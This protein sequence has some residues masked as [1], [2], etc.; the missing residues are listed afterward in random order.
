MKPSCKSFNP[1]FLA[2]LLW[3]V[4]S[5]GQDAP[6]DIYSTGLYISE[7][8]GVGLF[9]GNGGD[10]GIA[11][12]VE[13]ALINFGGQIHQENNAAIYLKQGVDSFRGSFQNLTDSAFAS[14]AGTIVLEGDLNNEGSFSHSGQVILQGD[15]EVFFYGNLTDTN[16][17]YSVVANKDSGAELIHVTTDLDVSNLIDYQGAGCF[18]TNNSTLYLRNADTSSLRGFLNPGTYSTISRTVVTMGNE[19]GFK[20]E[21]ELGYNYDFPVANPATY[22]PIRIRPVSGPLY[23]DVIIRLE[24]YAGATINFN[25]TYSSLPCSP[26]PI[27]FQYDCLLQ[28]GVWRIDGR[29]DGSLIYQTYSFPHSSYF[30]DCAPSGPFNFRT[31]RSPNPGGD[32]SPYVDSVMSQQDLCMFVTVNNLQDLDGQAIPGG[33]YSS[34]SSIGVGAGPAGGGTLPVEWLYFDVTGMGLSAQLNWGTGVEVN[35]RG[36]GIYRSETLE[37]FE[38]IG[39]VDATDDPLNFSE[40]QFLDANLEMGKTYYYRIKQEDLDGESFWSEIRSYTA[41]G[42]FSEVKAFPNPTDGLLVLEKSMEWSDEIEIICYDMFGLMKQVESI[43]KPKQLQV[44]LGF[45]PPGSYMIKATDKVTG[46]IFTKKVMK[47]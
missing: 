41:T 43:H 25:N 34:F 3:S 20:R 36:F 27:D 10:S 26:G 16:A 22:N 6:Q 19:G 32:W 29:D 1:T 33:I 18:I 28:N 37:E 46:E 11:L 17:L 5:Y 38:P 23:S 47:H 44:D 8:R 13:G 21:V 24:P 9:V 39:F 42:P 45:L 4:F 7:G 35:N 31:M 15:D 14:L 40:Y 30:N 2:L 12:T